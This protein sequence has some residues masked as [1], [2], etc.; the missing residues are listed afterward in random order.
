MK[1]G[2]TLASLELTNGEAANLESITHF[3]SF[4][5][6]ESAPV[7]QTRQDLNALLVGYIKHSRRENMRVISE[8]R[9]SRGETPLPKRLLL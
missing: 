6:Q 1:Y 8:L 9:V 5:H 3:I 4:M 7:P 2:N